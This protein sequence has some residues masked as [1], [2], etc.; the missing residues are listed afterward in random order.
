MNGVMPVDCYASSDV[1]KPGKHMGRTWG[2]CD[3]EGV[4]GTGLW[5]SVVWVGGALEDAVCLRLAFG[6]PAVT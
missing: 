5:L 3:V 1:G 2:Y 4:G 6:P